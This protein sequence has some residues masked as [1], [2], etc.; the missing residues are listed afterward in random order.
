MGRQWKLNL[1]T[2]NS[3]L[4]NSKATERHVNEAQGS[5]TLWAKEQEMA[6]QWQEP[7]QD[8]EY[9][10][11]GD[12]VMIGGEAWDLVS[13]Y[14]RAQALADGVLVDVT[15]TAAEAGFKYPV[16]VTRRVWDEVVT[17]DPRSVKWGQSERGRL[18]DVVWMFIVAGKRSAASTIH[19][20][21]SVIMKE[22]Q[23]RLITLKAICGPGDD[24]APVITIMFPEED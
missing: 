3:F 8:R 17:P 19:Y 23:A 12:T 14:T 21:L 18:W 24:G 6:Q 11:A 15:E 20:R 2:G 10:Q 16:A 5:L 1:D 4:V 9:A 13:V 7:P 22:R